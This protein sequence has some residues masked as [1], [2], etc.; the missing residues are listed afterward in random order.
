MGQI[1]YFKS[2][3]SLF[4]LNLIIFYNFDGILKE[5]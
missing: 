1:E 5:F 2:E 4:I 3:I